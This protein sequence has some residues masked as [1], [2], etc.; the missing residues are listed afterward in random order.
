MAVNID[1]SFPMDFVQYAQT[2]LI[3]GH[4]RK[5]VFVPVRHSE[6]IFA[7]YSDIHKQLWILDVKHNSPRPSYWYRPVAR[8]IYGHLGLDAEARSYER[9]Y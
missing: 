1:Y 9:V 8:F 7:K 3:V 5:D 4:G 6:E 2:P